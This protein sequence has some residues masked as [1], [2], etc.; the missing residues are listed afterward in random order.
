[1]RVLDLNKKKHFYTRLQ[2]K[3]VEHNAGK[4]N[5]GLNFLQGYHNTNSF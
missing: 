1:M 2:N 3:I 4:T 5:I